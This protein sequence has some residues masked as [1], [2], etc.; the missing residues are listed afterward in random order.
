MRARRQ[1]IS[2]DDSRGVVICVLKKSSLQQRKAEPEPR[3]IVMRI[4]GEGF[5]KLLLRVFVV[6]IAKCLISTLVGLSVADGDRTRRTRKRY[7]DQN[8]GK[9]F[10]CY[11]GEPPFRVK[12][13]HGFYLSAYGIL[14]Y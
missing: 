8:A 1:R 14:P 12:S 5:A 11:W 6:A 4:L 9:K 13:L 10:C 2:E 3:L 7:D